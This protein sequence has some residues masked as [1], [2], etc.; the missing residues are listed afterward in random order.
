M[1]PGYLGVAPSQVSAQV[2]LSVF[3][4]G[5]TGDAIQS[6]LLAVD[7]FGVWLWI[8]SVLFAQIV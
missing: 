4:D 5:E 2:P 3:R 7:C 1:I 6:G 8:C